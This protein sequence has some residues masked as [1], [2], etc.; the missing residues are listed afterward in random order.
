M[1]TWYEIKDKDDVS[2]SDD[3]KSLHVNFDGDQNGNIWVEIPL[4]FIAPLL[5]KGQPQKLEA[6]FVK[7]EGCE[8]AEGFERIVKESDLQKTAKE[9]YAQH[10]GEEG[11]Y[12]FTKYLWVSFP[13]DRQEC[14]LDDI[15][16]YD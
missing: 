11:Y 12:G 14:R 15:V 3:G 7:I 16:P 13:D 2:L 8:D 10:P 9:I 4:E 1:S 6:G 5:N